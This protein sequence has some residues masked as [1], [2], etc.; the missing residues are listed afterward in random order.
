M[1]L[2]LAAIAALA[3]ASANPAARPV[4]LP[5]GPRLPVSRLVAALPAPEARDTVF[6]YS[7]FYYKRLTVHRWGSY[8]MLPL[9]AAQ[10]LVGSKLYDGTA[11]DGTKDTHELIA[12]G[13][14]G[15][16]AINT[17]TGLWNL[18]DGR[19]DPKDRR[20]KFTHAAFMLAADAGFLTTGLLADDAE[21]GGGGRASTHR[22]VAIGSIAVSTVGW[23]MM[24]DLF[25]KD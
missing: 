13:V 4:D 1:D 8:T 7:S 5:A 6:E 10:Y 22:A 24:T 20:R 11:S 25:R 12:A 16:F 17:T 19:K 21:Q 15:L 9:F 3:F 18:W 14:A 23:L 2:T